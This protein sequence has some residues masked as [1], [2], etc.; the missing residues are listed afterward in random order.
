[1]RTQETVV[2]VQEAAPVDQRS[3]VSSR[4][5]LDFPGNRFKQHTWQMHAMSAGI[6]PRG[7]F[8]LDLHGLSRSAAHLAVQNVSFLVCI[9]SS[10]LAQAVVWSLHDC[11]EHDKQP[12]RVLNLVA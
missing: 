6:G 11:V 7:P 10:L 9:C 5:R 12:R 4:E 2:C 8:L 1:M 3:S